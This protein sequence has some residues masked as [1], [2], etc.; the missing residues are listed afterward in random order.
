MH[1]IGQVS[2]DKIPHGFKGRN[3]DGLHGG[4]DV[5]ARIFSSTR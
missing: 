2:E 1:Q 3:Q 5:G 4:G